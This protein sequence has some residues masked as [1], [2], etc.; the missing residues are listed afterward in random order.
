[1]IF[2]LQ[3]VQSARLAMG[4][5][6][7]MVLV[8]PGI[9][10]ASEC[11]NTQIDSYSINP[12]DRVESFEGFY[13]DVSADTDIDSLA[14]EVNGDEQPVVHAQKEDGGYKAIVL[15]THKYEG[16]IYIDMYADGLT[17]DA[18]DT[19]ISTSLVTGSLDTY[20]EYGVRINNQSSSASEASD[21]EEYAPVVDTGDSVVVAQ[22]A[23]DS[24]TEDEVSTQ[25]D[26]TLAVEDSQDEDGLEDDR[27][28]NLGGLAEDTTATD[29]DAEVLAN[30]G[31]DR[32]N[33]SSQAASVWGSITSFLKADTCATFGAS[34]P[35]YAWLGIIWIYLVALW[36]VVTYFVEPA[37]GRSDYA[38]RLV[39]TMGI[40]TA[41]ALGFWYFANPCFTH[42]WVPIVLIVL[43]ILLYWLYSEEDEGSDVVIETKDQ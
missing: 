12:G 13:F 29:T 31:D 7:S 17:D 2:N 35:W 22:D 6:M 26:T 4:V 11:R 30:A 19:P 18:C 42:V 5:L 24:G 33:D 10:S 9:V 3:G 41:L 14:V 34:W 25:E 36:L 16:S 32:S 21:D 20:N 8:A 43:G 39:W 37:I 23:T 38:T 40:G 27:Q 15:L 1:M 28:E